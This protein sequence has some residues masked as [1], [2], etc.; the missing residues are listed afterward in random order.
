MLWLRT[1]FLSILGRSV[2]EVF[3]VLHFLWNYASHTAPR[4]DN[5][6]ISF[7][8]QVY[9]RVHY[10][11]AGGLEYLDRRYR[12][13]DYQFRSFQIRVSLTVVSVAVVDDWLMHGAR[14][15]CRR[16][17]PDRR[18]NI[19]TARTEATLAHDHS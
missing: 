13:Y 11:L 1:A 3:L 18:R 12:W 6:S 5:V 10:R 14:A 8:Y 16:G 19:V 9:V 7:R 2:F 15:V 4:I 17:A